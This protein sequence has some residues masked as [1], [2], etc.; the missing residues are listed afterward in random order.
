MTELTILISG[1]ITAWLWP[2]ILAT[3]FQ[4]NVGERLNAGS[5]LDDAMRFFGALLAGYALIAV[6]SLV[7]ILVLA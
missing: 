6:I 7:L 4:P 2:G 5:N 3:A 1:V